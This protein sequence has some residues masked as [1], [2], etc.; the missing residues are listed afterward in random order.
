MHMPLS[1]SQR[2]KLTQWWSDKNIADKC[3]MCG[4]S[5]EDVGAADLVAVPM[6][7]PAGTRGEAIAMV[8][9]VCDHCAYVMLFAAKPMGLS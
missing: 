1:K 2:K 6:A 9:F 8:P 5:L 3:P 4:G 7:E